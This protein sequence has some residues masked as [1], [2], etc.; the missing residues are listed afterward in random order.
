MTAMMIHRRYKVNNQTLARFTMIP[1]TVSSLGGAW[2]KSE[3]VDWWLWIAT[4]IMNDHEW[5]L[6]VD[7]CRLLMFVIWWWLLAVVCWWLC[8]PWWWSYAAPDQLYQCNLQ[9]QPLDA[10]R[11]SLRGLWRFFCNRSAGHVIFLLV[12]LS[13]YVKTI[14]L[15]HF[16]GSD[17]IWSPLRVQ[18]WVSWSCCLQATQALHDPSLMFGES[19]V[20]EETGVL[21][22]E[23]IQPAKIIVRR[24]PVFLVV[25]STPASKLR[26]HR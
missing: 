5:S 8:G 7:C 20:Q 16:Y 2:T 26:W 21:A 14:Q 6:L 12:R 22:H 3:I 10:A 1:V 9:G 4:A 17:H 19:H 23:N 24:N 13:G 15:R 11:H 18:V 25:G